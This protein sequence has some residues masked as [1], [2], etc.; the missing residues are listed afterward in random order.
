MKLLDKIDYHK[1]KEAVNQVTIN[2]LF[3]RS[4]I[5]QH[6]SGTIYV[7]DTEDPETYYVIHPYGMSLLFGDCHNETFNKSFRDYVLNRHKPRDTD[8]WMQAWPDTWHHV[9]KG[10]LDDELKP[11]GQAGIVEQHT[12]VNFRFDKESDRKSVV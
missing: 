2:N 12:R 9:F 11:G 6:V 8:E 5:E 3:A 1:L 4:V 7:D 10:L